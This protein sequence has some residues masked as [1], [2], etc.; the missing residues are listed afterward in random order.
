LSDNNYK[1]NVSP[2]RW[3]ILL[4]VWASIFAALVAQFQVAALAYKIIPAFKMTTGQYSM[5]LTAPMLAGVCF[6]LVAGALADRFGVK[7]VVAVGF[8]FSIVGTFFRYAADTYWEM[9]ILMFL[10][11]I[12]P[13][14]LNANAAKLLGAWFPK[15]Q[16]GLVMGIY[17]KSNGMGITVALA[18][19]ALFP[20]TQSAFIA[21]GILIFAIWILWLLLIKAKPEGAPELPVMPMANYMSVA[22]KSKNVWLVGIALMFFMGSSM[23]FSGFLPNALHD[24]RGM[25]PVT[26]GF[27][28]SLITFGT[29]IGSLIG[30]IISDKLGR[31][32]YFIVPVAVIGATAGYLSW[33]SPQSNM[34]ALFFVFGLL[35]GMP[36]PMLMAF[37]MLLPEIGPVYAG[38]AGGIIGTLQ[39]VG[40]V[41]IPALVIA[42]IAGQNYT[43]FFTL[44]S[45]CFLAL[46]IVT[47]FLPELGTKA[48]KAKLN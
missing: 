41:F 4:I 38:S 23:A 27:M 47:L 31:I 5:V 28:A 24:Q 40:A 39:V 44:G 33:V 29:I 18:T 16:M 25:S 12:I 1:V 9:F 36:T 10:S 21:A 6:S 42:P 30:P 37:P 32:K 17:F 34:P 46:G 19:T 3:V 2:Y 11:G 8:V 43:I 7:R 22:A 14:L 13:G 35:A 48:T 26:A 20:T 45:L 15:E